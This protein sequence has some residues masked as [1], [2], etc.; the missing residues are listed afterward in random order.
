MTGHQPPAIIRSVMAHTLASISSRLMLAA[1]CVPLSAC[2]TMKADHDALA[3]EV[4]TLRKK[5][6][7]LNKEWMKAT[8][9]TEALQAQQK[10]FEKKAALHDA[11]ARSR[12]LLGERPRFAKARSTPCGIASD[13]RRG[14]RCRSAVAR[15]RGRSRWGG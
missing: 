4:M 6:A 3:S 10:L 2:I 15:R 12:K 7:K 8:I 1:L 13:P 14:C 11:S 5:V 9:A